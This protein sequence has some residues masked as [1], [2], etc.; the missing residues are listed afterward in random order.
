M[1]GPP[2][3]QTC[4]GAMSIHDSI[5][6]AENAL[7]ALLLQQQAGVD[8]ATGK[9][10]TSEDLIEQHLLR[11]FLPP[12]FL[13][14]KGAVVAAATPSQQS[15]AIDR[16]VHDPTVAAPLVQGAAHS[17]FPIEAVAG[18]VEVTMR[19]NATKLRQDIVKIAQIQTWRRRRYVV[20][21]PGSITHTFRAEV[22]ALSPRGFV[23]GLPADPGWRPDT[24][25]QTLR[26]TLLE[27]GGDVKIHGLF[28]IGIGF[29]E[30][31]PASEGQPHHRVM[32]WTNGDRLFRFSN[33]FRTAFQRWPRME[34]GWAGDL[35]HYVDGHGPTVLAP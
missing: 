30:T 22:D 11:P 18:L 23:I 26:A 5:Q 2:E 35:D 3:R 19:L 14:H 16:V 21:L 32:A 31:I 12:P 17:I 6:E 28:V 13:T 25:A 7:R 10:T 4:V 34:L 33:S 8:D 15:A 1:N 9:G 20:P 29:F 24:I 27:L